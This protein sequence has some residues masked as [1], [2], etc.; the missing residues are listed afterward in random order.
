MKLKLNR[1]AR[2]ERAKY[3][4]RKVIDDMVRLVMASPDSGQTSAETQPGIQTIEVKLRKQHFQYIK[5]LQRLFMTILFLFK[6]TKHM[7]C[8]VHILSLLIHIHRLQFSH[9]L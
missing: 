1:F 6:N 9:I 5:Y 8:F 7:T 2:R 4:Q 3:R